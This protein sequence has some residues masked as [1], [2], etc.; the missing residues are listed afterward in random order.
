MDFSFVVESLPWPVVMVEEEGKITYANAAAKKIFGAASRLPSSLADL[1]EFLP[2]RWE[3]AGRIFEVRGE[4]TEKGGLLFFQDKSDSLTW[5]E[6]FHVLADL[7][8]YSLQIIQIVDGIPQYVYVNSAFTQR[9]GY[10]KDDLRGRSVYEIID[11]AYHDLIRERE[12]QRIQGDTDRGF[13]ELPVITK[14]GRRIWVRAI[15]SYIAYYGAPAILCCAYDITDIKEVDR[16]LKEANQGFINIINALPFATFAIDLEGKVIG[17]NKTMETLTGI[18]AREIVGQ[19]GRAYAKALY[20][21]ERPIVIDKVLDS[22]V[23]LGDTYKDVVERNGIWYARGFIRLPQGQESFYLA[24]ANCLRDGEGNVIGAVE[25]IIDLTRQYAAEEALQESEKRFR[26]LAEESPDVIMLF[27]R[28]GRHLYC[29]SAIKRYTSLTPTD[30]IGR[31]HRDLNFPPGLVDEVERAIKEVF[32]TGKTMRRQLIMSNGMCFDWLLSPIKS[33]N[34]EVTHVITSS[35]EITEMKKMEEALIRSEKMEAI[36]NLAGGVAH[37]FNNILQ[38]VLGYATLIQMNHPK[39]SDDHVRAQLIINAATSAMELIKRLLGFARSTPGDV[40]TF[41]LNDEI[42]K[43]VQMYGRTKKGIEI[44]IKLGPNLPS[45]EGD[46]V[47]IE[48]VFLNILV[49]AGQAMPEGG[50]IFVETEEVEIDEQTARIHR[51]KAGHY[52]KVSITDTGIGMDEETRSKIFEPFFT[53]KSPE[54]GTGLGLTTAYGIVKAHHGFINVYSELGRGTTFSV[55]LP[56]SDKAVVEHKEKGKT[57]PTGCETILVVDDE[58]PVLD[59]AADILSY[60]GYTVLKASGGEEAISI[61]RERKADI[62]LVILDMIMPRMN[63]KDVFIR[64]KEIDPSVRVCITTG[65]TQTGQALEMLDLGVKA[66]IQKPYAIS[67]LAHRIR[68]ILD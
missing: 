27:D 36:G 65:Y 26:A 4:L 52:V 50:D 2:T 35:R 53:T 33:Q 62:D 61:Y 25:S 44:H 9:M 32:R 68:E 64:L 6:Q 47:Q 66:F 22:R 56:A 49:N 7:L 8:P 18:S 54:E 21:D 3:W 46:R 40:S 23:E 57:A 38:A 20:G 30:F 51:V 67:E 31:T 5:E 10:T 37:D 1:I 59:V 11:P 28:E 45:V 13:Y 63:G 58:L 42:T 14:E 43:I 39:G 29:N 55:Y 48:Q 17:W 24:V 41:D 34:G 12:A 60:L 19:G 16:I 15:T